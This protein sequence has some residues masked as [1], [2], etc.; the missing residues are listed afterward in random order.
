MIVRGLSRGVLAGLVAITAYLLA[1]QLRF[2]ASAAPSRYQAFAIDILPVVG[3]A[4]FLAGCWRPVFIRPARAE[5]HTAITRAVVASMLLLGLL[6]LGG[7]NPNAATA[8]SNPLAPLFPPSSIVG[9]FAALM[10]AELLACRWL[11]EPVRT[12]W[13]S[14]RW[15]VSPGVTP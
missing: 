2:A 9:L 4:G 7:L 12:R 1:W 3:L 5:W 13:V 6:S 15:R 11:M 14:R 8:R 10:A